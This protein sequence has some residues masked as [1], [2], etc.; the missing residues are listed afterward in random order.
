MDVPGLGRLLITAGVLLL[1]VGVL[2]VVGSKIPLV[3]RLPGDLVFRKDG[4]TVFVP[5]ATMLI[6]SLA[7][8]ILVN[9]FLR[10]FR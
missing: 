1:V 10:L 3:G 7:L 4:L 5:L 6:L 8:T 2:L 9:L